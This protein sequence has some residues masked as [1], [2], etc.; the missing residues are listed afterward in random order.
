M[1][2]LSIRVDAVTSAY[3]FICRPA[4]ST[5]CTVLAIDRRAPFGRSV[6]CFVRS[7]GNSGFCPS[8]QHLGLLNVN[9]MCYR[10]WRRYCLRVLL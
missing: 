4:E 2:S 9:Q 8:S 3:G 1:W 7:M 5:C 10:I 6:A